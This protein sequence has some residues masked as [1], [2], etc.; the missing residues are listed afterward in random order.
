MAAFTV[1][2]HYEFTGLASSYGVTGFSTA[3]DHLLWVLSVRSDSSGGTGYDI[4]Y[5]GLRLGTSGSID[6]G[7]NYSCTLLEATTSTPV[8][9][10]NSSQTSINP[11]SHL[12][13]NA[14]ADSFSTIKIWVPNYSAAGNYKTALIQV[15]S[16][17]ASTTNNDWAVQSLAGLYKGSTAAIDSILALDLTA[18]NFVQY[19]TFTLY[20]VTGA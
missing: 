18:S 8:S 16:S 3:Y 14:T 9:S 17:S 19:S 20:G 4:D 7:A 15:A 6:T 1:I 5:G 13:T 11:W 10:G 2:N 12:G